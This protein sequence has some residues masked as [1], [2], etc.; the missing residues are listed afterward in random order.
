MKKIS[1]IGISTLLATQLLAGLGDN[2]YIG[3][4]I[5]NTTAELKVSAGGVSAAEDD[6]GGS[7]TLKVGAY[8][9]KNSRV[10]G[11]YH[12]V[13][14]DA[15]NIGAVGIGYDYFM[16]TS[17]FKPFVGGLIGYGSYTEDGLDFDVAGLVYGVQAGVNYAI[18]DNFS[19]EAGYR[20]LKSNMKDSIV[21]SGVNYD[22]EMNDVR[23]GFFGL[24]YKF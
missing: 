5:G 23:I 10:Y 24:N 20:F 12:N 22:L 11:F 18:N 9:D 7:Q 2:L 15:G 13:N 1:I 17:A 3:A 14:I 21:F 8:L 16:G 4:D 6:N 19:V